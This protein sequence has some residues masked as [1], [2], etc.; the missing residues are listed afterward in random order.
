MLTRDALEEVITRGGDERI[1]LDGHGRNQYGCAVSTNADE[2]SFASSTASTW[3]DGARQAVT[4]AYRALV[5]LLVA[6]T[7]ID[8][9]YDRHL[10]GLRKRFLKYLDWTQTGVPDLIF[11]PSGTD[12]HLYVSCLV[13]S[14][15]SA[16]TRVITVEA[17]ETGSRIATAVGGAHFSSVTALG[18]N[19]VRGTNLNGTAPPE[20]LSIKLR[21]ADGNLRSDMQI[22]AD[23][24]ICIDKAS[25]E[26]K[27]VLLVVTD[28]SKTGLVSPGIASV[29]NIRERWSDQV[30]VLI[31]ACQFRLAASTLR[32]YIERDFLVVVT[33][34]KFIGGPAFSGLVICP[35]RYAER[36]K[37]RRLPR[38]LAA[39]SNRAEW[40]RDWVARQSMTRGINLGL[41]CRW[42]AALYELETF[43]TIP[44][45]LL[46][47]IATTF[48]ESVQRKITSSACLDL[49]PSRS[50]DR[51]D[52]GHSDCWD[53]VPTIFPFLMKEEAGAYLTVEGTERVFRD[54][55]NSAPF[56]R[57]GQP[58]SCG[59]RNGRAV[60]ALR[61]CLSAGLFVEAAKSPAHL[62]ALIAR[63]HAALD[64]AA[65]YATGR[66]IER[67]PNVETI[68]MP[69]PSRELISA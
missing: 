61:L 65:D 42:E 33:G 28:V 40:P 63:A 7:Q 26:G 29:L 5:P 31:D 52:I 34:S 12:A 68:L 53:R 56:V 10:A 60:N 18:E 11:A 66:S 43:S 59:V 62:Q 8:E 37:Y 19:V 69:R 36:F 46:R 39:Y 55:A 3:S 41:V 67:V 20:H 22:E 30:D 50:L 57:L 64:A 32:D 24:S 25:R 44:E 54:L 13:N 27:R 45:T 1:A 49:I 35:P 17:A 23:I 16:S 47:R 2:I 6:D 48:A 58:V 51:G 4:K 14:D 21:D 38:S 9:A 15:P